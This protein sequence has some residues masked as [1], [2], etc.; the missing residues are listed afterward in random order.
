M[1]YI[2]QLPGLY[3]DEEKLKYFPITK[4]K[5]IID[6]TTSK[7]AEPARQI[8][9]TPNL[10]KNPHRFN[11]AINLYHQTLD[12][13]L[14]K[15]PNVK[16]YSHFYPI[17]A[18]A[19][20]AERT[21]AVATSQLNS[22]LQKFNLDTEERKYILESSPGSVESLIAIDNDDNIG[23]YLLAIDKTLNRINQRREFVKYKSDVVSLSALTDNECV[24]IFIS[25]IKRVFCAFLCFLT[26]AMSIESVQTKAFQDQKPGTSGLRK[27]VKVFQQDHYTENFVWA[28][29]QAMSN[30]PA[31]GSTLV[32]GGDGRYYG[33]ECA[34]KVLKLSAAAGVKKVIVGQNAILSTPAASNLI[35]KYKADGGILM[36]ASH[37]PGGPDN[38]FGIKFNVANGGPAPE[39]VTN[40]I[41][42]ITKS[43]T[44]YS[45]A[46]L[47]DLDISKVGNF[48][49]GNLEVEVVDSV[50]D[51][52]ELL[53]GIFDFD[54]IKKFLSENPS[55]KFLFD[56]LSGVTGSYGQAIFL[57]ELG[58]S[59]DSVQNAVPLPDFGGL[60]P[61]PNLT[62]AHDLVERV[63][64]D[65][66]TFGAASDGDGDRNMIIGKGV[67]VTPS[68]SVAIIADWA[69]VIP[70][71]KGGLKGLA[72]SMP[73][74]GAID[75]VAKVKNV[76]G[77][78]VPTGWKFF[79]NLMDAGK[80]SI[81]GEESFGTGS[82]HIRE[83]DGLWAIV[84][85]LNII[86]AANQE[87]KGWNIKD[88]LQ[89]HYNK[90]GRNFFSRYDY[91]EVDSQAANN[92]IEHLTKT[93]ETIDG[94]QLKAT[95][96]D[97]TF[98]VKESGNF[99]YTD[100]IDGSV[101]KNQGLYIV[102]QD[103]SRVIVR[104]SGTGSSGATIRLYVEKYSTESSEYGQDAQ[105]GLLPLIE[106]A[107]SL[108]KL[109]E[110]T[111]RTKPTVIT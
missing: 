62:Y 78:E 19:S 98:T 39:S 2:G 99:S 25:K 108:S 55:F 89:A 64:K 36:T 1:T 26:N 30:P 3:W 8:Q 21:I 97:T 66:I 34:Q 23:S 12:R 5:P 101:S 70:Y 37:N 13:R 52:V 94:T 15:Q 24:P 86:A 32:L 42:N 75:R 69:H 95:T 109:Q 100:P 46:Q 60:H 41:F 74:S 77:F 87:H 59:K 79:G 50:K 63:E 14:R 45:I 54:L 27:R 47:P 17:S 72:R 82:D 43:L 51:Y 111:G 102:F 33:V 4:K 85:W 22:Q 91:E 93:F 110:F 9:L 67:F 40:E 7:P 73:T 92:M 6:N 38:D 107:L 29:L 106:V 61:D 31:K 96:S 80:L 104:L 103:G 20:L 57:G 83:K 18:A 35:R 88:I 44:S 84:A 56:G 49:H 71:F 11:D 81:C 90:Y 10:I 48:K 68:D 28:T 76:E 53:K 105:V 58:L 65:D 16:I